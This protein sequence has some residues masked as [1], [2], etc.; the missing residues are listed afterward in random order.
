MAAR[1][2][3]GMATGQSI[4]QRPFDIGQTLVQRSSKRHSVA[5]T[6]RHVRRQ[7][8][9][10]RQRRRL[11]VQ[12]GPSTDKSV[13]GPTGPSGLSAPFAPFELDA[14]FARFCARRR[15]PRRARRAA[16]ARSVAADDDRRPD[17]ASNSPSDGVEATLGRQTA[18]KSTPNDSDNCHNEM[19]FS[20][21]AAA[22]YNILPAGGRAGGPS[23]AWPCRAGGWR[24]V[25][26]VPSSLGGADWLVGAARPTWLCGASV[27]PAAA[28]QTAR[29]VRGEAGAA[30]IIIYRLRRSGG[31]ASFSARLATWRLV[32]GASTAPSDRATS[33]EPP[34]M[35]PNNQRMA[36]KY[37]RLQGASSAATPWSR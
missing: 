24:Q 34:R 29:G 4:R 3:A 11:A 21:L 19:L 31:R 16:P 13:G 32:R 1:A 20:V 12:V 2:C 30:T 27:F 22:H 8:A 35:A 7:I 9:V 14:P 5:V 37:A 15:R 10:P 33:H 36:S 26:G 18:T 17:A 6:T 25:P 28:S 23:S